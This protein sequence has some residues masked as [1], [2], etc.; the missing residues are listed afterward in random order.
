MAISKKEF[1][2][3]IEQLRLVIRESTKAFEDDSPKAKRARI[4]RSR[5]NELYFGKMYFPHYFT[6]RF[7]K[8][9]RDLIELCNKAGHKAVAAPRGFGKSAIC[10]FLHPIHQGVFKLIHFF[11]LISSTEINAAEFLIP[12][13][14]EFE[15]NERLR[16][17]FGDLVNF[18]FWSDNDF[19][20][21]NGIR[22]LGIGS[23]QKIRG[24]RHRQYRPDL[25][26]IEDI[27]DDEIVKK[28]RRVKKIV[29]WIK[30]AVLPA[31]S[32]NGS[33]M[34]V[35]TMLSKNSVLAQVMELP[36]VE[37]KVFKAIVNDKSTWPAM[38]PM[39]ALLR[40][41]MVIGSIAFNQE[42]QQE[43][44]DDEE[45]VFKETWIRYYQPGILIGVPLKTYSWVDP[46]A[47]KDGCYKA[48]VTVG[49]D[50]E[51]LIYYVLHAWIKK[52]SIDSLISAGYNIY[53]EY[54]PIK[55]GIEKNGF[56]ALIAREYDHYAKDVKKY[57]LPIVL[58]DN[59]INKDVRIERRSPLVERGKIRFIKGQ[60]D[61]D[62]LVEQLLYFP[63]IE[64]DGPDALDGVLQLAEVSLKEVGYKSA[65]KRRAVFA[66]GAF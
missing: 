51:N 60:S 27:E 34:F 14:L 53:E 3:K 66:K 28:P 37:S 45:R 25:I 44:K 63:D 16:N 52:A 43:P 13:K 24:R 21:K 50:V 49:L 5:K 29:D 31:L 22:Y 47:T 32:K 42:F 35:E 19:V 6:A 46:A 39:S 33:L 15:E 10:S 30:R 65:K 8:L 7:A 18:G 26:M 40:E 48:I 59:T 17:D 41:K 20:L 58:R 36:E 12:I 2:K 61:Q 11:I 9:H 55:I 23:G 4:D 56:Q 57:N 64:K 62:L 1:E 54:H 38:W